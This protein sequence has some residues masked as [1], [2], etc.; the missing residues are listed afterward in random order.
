MD[1]KRLSTASS[2]EGKILTNNIELPNNKLRE[3]AV[4][5]A[6]ISLRQSLIRFL[7]LRSLL[8]KVAS[9]S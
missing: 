6:G 2:L 5:K 8:T 1:E 3:R 9:V 4:P 7:K